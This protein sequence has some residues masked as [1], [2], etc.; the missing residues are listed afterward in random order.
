V[1]LHSPDSIIQG[2]EHKNY[3]IT[4][5]QGHP[6]ALAAQGDPMAIKL[7]EHFLINPARNRI[8]NF[9]QMA[10]EYSETFNNT[11]DHDGDIVELSSKFDKLLQIVTNILKG[12]GNLSNSN[13]KNTPEVIT[14]NKPDNKISKSNFSEE[15]KIKANEHDKFGPKI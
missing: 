2:L 8:K 10:K 13:I 9:D 3:D 15:V 4:L 14:S 11:V 5:F 12:T 6:E 1:N 7:V